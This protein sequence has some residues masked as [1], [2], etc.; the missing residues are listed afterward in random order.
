MIKLVLSAALNTETLH[1]LY[2]I[3]ISNM[4]VIRR[5]R[6]S[7]IIIGIIIVI[8]VETGMYLF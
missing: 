3:K 8:T 5:G 6:M 2:V 4:Y 1:V 7:V